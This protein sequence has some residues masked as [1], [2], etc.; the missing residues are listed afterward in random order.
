MQSPFDTYFA[1]PVLD[2]SYC[3]VASNSTD[4][5]I[6]AANVTDI[7][8]HSTNNK[9]S[10]SKPVTKVFASFIKPYGNGISS[11]YLIYQSAIPNINVDYVCDTSMISMGNTCIITLRKMENNNVVNNYLIGLLFQNTG[12]VKLDISLM[13]KLNYINL[14]YIVYSFIVL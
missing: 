7:T 6:N 11:P 10:P 3:L 12:Y 8:V 5:E 14:Y 1:F 2:G 4:F 13:I 9:P